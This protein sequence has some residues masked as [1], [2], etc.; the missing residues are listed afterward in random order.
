MGCIAP[1]VEYVY[2]TNLYYWS[3]DSS[4]HSVMT[5]RDCEVAGLPSSHIIEVGGNS[6]TWSPKAY[7]IML[8]LR[9]FKGF[10]SPLF[11]MEVHVSL[12]SADYG[13]LDITAPGPFP[14]PTSLAG[15]LDVEAEECC[16]RIEHLAV[17]V[18]MKEVTA[19][20]VILLVFI[21]R[22]LSINRNVSP[23]FSAVKFMGPLYVVLNGDLVSIKPIFTL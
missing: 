19:S 11:T 2:R 15:E 9:K 3:S 7:E 20:C 14:T 21:C 5:E 6:Q 1:T 16:S 17:E 18:D 23:A 4:R 13:D 10:L 12:S 22:S 8:E